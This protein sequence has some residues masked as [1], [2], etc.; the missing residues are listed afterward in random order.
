MNLAAARPRHY[1]VSLHHTCSDAPSTTH[2]LTATSL[3]ELLRVI[4]SGTHPELTCP[5]C[6]SA[7]VTVSSI[8]V[9]VEADQLQ[10]RLGHF[11][12]QL[13]SA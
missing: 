3:T 8:N 12:G 10:G 2:D 5:A 13:V 6:G 1:V 11:A 9:V 7:R 4:R